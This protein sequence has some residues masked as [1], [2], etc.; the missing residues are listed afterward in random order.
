MSNIDIT[1]ERPLLFLILIPA[2]ILGIIPFLRIQKRRRASTKHLIPFI[3]HL[4]LV[5]V[6]SGL[7]GGVVATE[8]TDEKL[9]T[10]VV[11]VADVSD[12]NIAMKDEMNA[13]IKSVIKEADK[14]K[15]KFGLVM[16]ANNVVKIVDEGEFSTSASDFLKFDSK[17]Q[18]TDQSNH[19]NHSLV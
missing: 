18:K 16:F 19:M 12:S 15:T 6:L 3:I 17:A 1:V 14:D 5:F 11:F 9:E 13:F 10:K 2:L 4:I 7:L 8:V